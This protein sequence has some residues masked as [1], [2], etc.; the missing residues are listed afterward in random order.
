MLF[1]RIWLTIFTD[2]LSQIQIRTTG[3]FKHSWL[4]HLR[5]IS[6][7]FADNSRARKLSKFVLNLLIMGY[8]KT[9]K[10]HKNI[11]LFLLVLHAKPLFRVLGPVEGS[12]STK[13]FPFLNS[14]NPMHTYT[15]YCSG[16]E[17]NAICLH[18]FISPFQWPLKLWTPS[19]PPQPL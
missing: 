6:P 1:E 16:F 14:W 9:P 19:K 13:C 10:T 11:K 3:K 18:F 7:T 5:T 12:C 17:K 15:L 2:F 8:C 4:S